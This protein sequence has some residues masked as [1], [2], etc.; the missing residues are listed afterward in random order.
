VGRR[1]TG[2]SEEFG[3]H[4]HCSMTPQQRLLVV[5]REVPRQLQLELY[6][7]Q[8]S[9]RVVARA[10]DQPDSRVREASPRAEALDVDA[11]AR[12]QR[13]EEDLEW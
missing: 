13:R 2:T 10:L 4:R 3:A 7:L 6:R 9:V 5:R 12:S 8:S 11:G 1:V